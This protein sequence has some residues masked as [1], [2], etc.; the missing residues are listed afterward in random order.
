LAAFPFLLRV[1][2]AASHA[3]LA[4]LA[5]RAW[6]PNYMLGAALAVALIG[7]RAALPMDETVAVLALAAGGV[8]AYWG[9][10]YG[11]VLDA[12]ERALVRRA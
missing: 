12:S 6:A 7:G 10:F 1:G 2:L 9:V 8:L 3:P 4:E 5:R 11:L